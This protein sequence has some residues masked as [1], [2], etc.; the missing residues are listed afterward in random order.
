[1]QV[2][3]KAHVASN[4]WVLDSGCSRH[5]SGNSTKFITL[6][7]KIGGSVTF[8]DNKKG[9]I[10]G[11]GKVGNNKF[12][13]DNVQLVDGLKYNLII[14]SQLMDNGYQVNFEKDKCLILHTSFDSPVCEIREGNIYTINFDSQVADICLSVTQEQTILWHKRMGHVHMDLIKTL[15]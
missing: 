14:V 8:G 10:I 7:H 4:K 3:L 6:E 13:I 9:R 15:G 1:M 11:K 2:C 5:M 12:A